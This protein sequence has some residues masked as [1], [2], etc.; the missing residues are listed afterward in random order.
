MLK[1]I[2]GFCTGNCIWYFKTGMY[3]GRSV[4][5]DCGIIDYVD[6]IFSGQ[7][8]V[9]PLSET[10]LESIQVLATCHALA[11]LDDGLVGDPL[12]KATLTAVDWNLTKGDAVIPKRGKAPGMKIFHR[13][14]FS[15]A[16][17][18]MSVIAGYTL[19]GSTDTTYITTVK[20]APETLKT[21]VSEM[22]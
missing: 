10:P 6:I 11:Q 21:M 13:H 3:E 14:H 7:Q 16:L 15:S 2:Y 17:K 18:R 12:E 8:G 9:V 20:G 22:W 4:F 5:R 19:P 1:S